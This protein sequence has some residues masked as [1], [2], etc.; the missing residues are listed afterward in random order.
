MGDLIHAEAVSKLHSYLAY[1]PSPS[2]YLTLTFQHWFKYCS[3]AHTHEHDL[4]TS[5]I[6]KKHNIKLETFQ[7]F[8]KIISVFYSAVPCRSI[9]LV[10]FPHFVLLQ[11]LTSSSFT[12]TAQSIIQRLKKS[13]T[14]ANLARRRLQQKSS[15]EEVQWSRSFRDN[16]LIEMLVANFANLAFLE[17][18]QE[19]R[20]PL[21]QENHKK[22]PLQFATI[23]KASTKT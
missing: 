21:L 14:A 1:P 6:N 12:Q 11:P 3:L 19:A 13:G 9:V 7:F 17:K 20:K 10:L 4:A 23:R 5:Q 16:L 22:D 2:H 8:S 15:L 18:Q